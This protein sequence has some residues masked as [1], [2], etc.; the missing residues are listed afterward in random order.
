MS[1]TSPAYSPAITD[2]PLLRFVHSSDD[3]NDQIDMNGQEEAEG[4]ICNP[5]N[6]I[7]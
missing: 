3:P 7:Y 5:N 6:S 2:L 1:L 4:S